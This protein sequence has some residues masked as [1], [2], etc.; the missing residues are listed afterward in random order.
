MSVLTSLILGIVL[1]RFRKVRI[2]QVTVHV[3]SDSLESRESICDG[4]DPAQTCRS[5]SRLHLLRPPGV[6]SLQ[7]AIF[8]EMKYPHLPA[9]GARQPS[10]VG[11]LLSGSQL[12]PQSYTSP[13]SA[14]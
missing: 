1:I 4:R 10:P 2:V 14:R 6:R 12:H 11:I 13:S 7:R 9:L 5:F 3:K 8:S